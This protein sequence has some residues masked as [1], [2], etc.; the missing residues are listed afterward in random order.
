MSEPLIDITPQLP[1]PKYT[2]APLDPGCESEGLIVCHKWAP[3]A[4]VL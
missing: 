4:L 2:K 3:R 1:I